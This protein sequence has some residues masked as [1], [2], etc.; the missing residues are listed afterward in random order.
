MKSRIAKFLLPVAFAGAGVFAVAAPA[1]AA[2]GCNGTV[3]IYKGTIYA[4]YPAYNG[5]GG[6]TMRQG[7]SG[8][9]VKALQNALNSCYHAGLGV[10][11][12][13]G[14]NTFRALKSAQS[15]AGATPD[16]VYGPATAGKIKFQWKYDSSGASAGCAPRY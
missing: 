9:E 13:F 15:D 12:I 1:Q 3:N 16:G 2:S 6:C 4:T 5:N 7:A 8:P 10:D 11:G 14:D